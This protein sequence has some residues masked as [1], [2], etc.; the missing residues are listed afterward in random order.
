MKKEIKYII[1]YYQKHFSNYFHNYY[2]KIL[3][4]KF[5]LK[6]LTAQKNILYNFNNWKRSFHEFNYH[7]LKNTIFQFKYIHISLAPDYS[8]LFFEKEKW[9]KNNEILTFI[10]WFKIKN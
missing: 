2:V 7:D 6:I 8:Y 3:K 9:K 5:L 1:K 4:M 10:R